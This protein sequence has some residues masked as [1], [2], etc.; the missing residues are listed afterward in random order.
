LSC[1]K[2]QANSLASDPWFRKFLSSHVNNTVTFVSCFL[3]VWTAA[4][5]GTIRTIRVP[6]ETAEQTLRSLEAR[7]ER[8]IRS[9]ENWTAFRG[10]TFSDALPESGITFRHQVVDEAGKRF[11]PNHYDHGTGVAAADVDGDGQTDLFFVNQRGGNELWRNLGNM[12]F[13]NITPAAGVAMEESICI[14]ASFGDIDNDGLPDLFVTTVKMGNRLFHN[15][16]GGRFRDIS[17]SA[18]IRE[19]GH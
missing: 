1:A 6:G 9:A 17:H 16:G 5:Q 14:G 18:G 13:E 8:Q 7:K 3:L 12:R 11:K 15:L 2:D 4:A 19:I 10:F